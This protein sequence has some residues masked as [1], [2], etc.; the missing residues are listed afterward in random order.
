MVTASDERP[1]F[2]QCVNTAVG[3][4]RKMPLNA[5]IA[6]TKHDGEYCS[7]LICSYVTVPK[8][9]FLWISGGFVGFDTPKKNAAQA[10]QSRTIVQQTEMGL[11]T[12][13]C[14]EPPDC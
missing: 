8:C 11:L 13:L 2:T 3:P 6:P 7:A 14:L 10:T 4:I 12:G 9:S 5:L 1:L